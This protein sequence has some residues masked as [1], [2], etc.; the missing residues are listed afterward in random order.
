M[1]KPAYIHLNIWSKYYLSSKRAKYYQYFTYYM[2]NQ[3]RLGNWLVSLV[4]FM[5]LILGCF[6]G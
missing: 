3:Y 4:N 6:I 1:V 5:R 2:V